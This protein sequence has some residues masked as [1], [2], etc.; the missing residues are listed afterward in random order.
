MRASW[1]ALI[2]Q[3]NKELNK[4]IKTFKRTLM[5]YQVKELYATAEKISNYSLVKKVFEGEDIKDVKVMASTLV[6]YP[7]T[8][9]LLATKGDKA[10]VVFSCSK[11][12]PIN[13]NQLFKE[14]I[15]LI[16]GKGG[17]NATSAQG[18]GDEVYNLEGLMEAAH[19][20]IIMEY[21]K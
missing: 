18:G 6:Q 16:N 3:E 10:Q 13:M 21:I 5:D 15:P 20:K 8:I 17:G 11:E 1:G 2:F 4:T 19:K 14:V 9:S 12:V 7:N